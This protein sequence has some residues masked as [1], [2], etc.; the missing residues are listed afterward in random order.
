MFQHF[1]GGGGFGRCI[2]MMQN[3]SLCL[4]NDSVI[5]AGNVAELEDKT[6]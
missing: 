1:Y 6:A 5:T 4:A 3:L 2:V